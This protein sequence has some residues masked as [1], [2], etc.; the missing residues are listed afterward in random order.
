MAVS[1]FGS[2]LFDG[3]LDD[4]RVSALFG[5]EATIS[6]ML[7]VEAALA[8]AQ[9]SLDVI[10][11]EAADHIARTCEAWAPP[12]A[13]L[14]A[15]AARDGTPVPAL[16][17]GL[18]EAVGKDWA[19]CVHRGATSQD[20]ADTAQALIL[21]DVLDAIGE[22]FS[23]LAAALAALADEH[24]HTVCVARTRSVQAV[25]TVFGLRA[26]NWLSGVARA[27]KTLERVRA[28]VLVLSL[29]GAAGTMAALGPRAFETAQA[30]AAVLGL[31]C[32]PAPWH[33][34]RDRLA[35]LAA[36]SASLAASLGK[37]GADML[38]MAQSE[39]GEICFEKAGCSST[40]PNKSN[41]VLPEILVALAGHAASLAASMHRAEVA[42]NERD[43]ATWMLEWLVLPQA[44]CAAAAATARAL[45]AIRTLRVD[46]TR[47][48]ANLEA[49][50]GC[51]LAEAATFALMRDMS[52]DQA[53]GLVKQA[54]AAASRGVHMVDALRALA[55]DAVVDWAA[56]REPINA[57]GHAGA[58]IDAILSDAGTATI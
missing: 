53:A 6:A 34:G 26:A 17:D 28:D 11:V 10:P 52:R 40:M 33:T 22:R 43:G 45:E 7:R 54:C 8:R 56:L 32:P 30:M 47:M 48:H 14:A 4:A 44:V 3:S 50:N 41:P 21:R 49:S 18:R 25:P 38:V 51:I 27:R 20:I 58:L 36:W 31:D 2:A 16:V 23:A 42:A 57:T 9:A 15:A 1:P 29:G 5:D 39:V 37:M 46:P 55:P 19:D 12:A 35:A 24:R 13:S